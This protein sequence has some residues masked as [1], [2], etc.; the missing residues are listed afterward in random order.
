MKTFHVIISPRARHSLKEIVSY[1]KVESP[2]AAKHV[3]KTL[4]NLI[5]TLK[6]SPEKFSTESLLDGKQKTTG[7]LLSGI[8]KLS[9]W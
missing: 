7:R 1:I 9:I 3:R 2:R 6:N 5:K 8:I 4:I